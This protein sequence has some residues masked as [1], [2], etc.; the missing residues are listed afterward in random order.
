MIQI[1]LIGPLIYYII[2]RMDVYGFIVCFIV[3][4]CWEAV[5]Y[6]VGVSDYIYKLLAIRYVSLFAFGVLIAI[7]KKINGFALVMMFIIGIVWQTLLNYVPLQPLFMNNA[8]ARVNLYSSLFVLPP[9]Y[10]VIKKYSSTVMNVPLL[11]ELGKASFNIFLFQM[12]FYGCGPAQIVYKLV[13]NAVFQFVVCMLT[14]TLFGYLY[15]RIENPITK[16]IVKTINSFF[17]FKTK[18]VA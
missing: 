15:Y 13:D 17:E 9:M 10:I 14:C 2:K 1:I 3:T 4:G 16:K 5:L 8:W 18:T 7:G 11:Q 12:V 6:C